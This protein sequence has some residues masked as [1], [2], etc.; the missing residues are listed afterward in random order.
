MRSR[1]G[2]ARA[3]AISRTIKTDR[4]AGNI[5]GYWREG[6]GSDSYGEHREFSVASLDDAQLPVLKE[7]LARMAKDLKEECIYIRTGEIASLL[8]PDA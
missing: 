5:F 6:D 4:R 2:T 8:Y 7:F 1:H 3:Q